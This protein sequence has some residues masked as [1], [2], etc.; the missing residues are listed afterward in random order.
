MYKGAKVQYKKYQV[1]R[2]CKF[3]A[4]KTAFIDYKNVK[5]LRSY[6]TEKGKIMA[7]R[8][9][10]T[11]SKHQRELTAAIKKARSIALMPFVEQ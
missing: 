1:R 5:M 2:F 11:C 4:D 10:S 6:V 7:G 8:M 3:C 9:T